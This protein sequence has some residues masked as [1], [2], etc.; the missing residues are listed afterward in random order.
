MAASD[1]D[2]PDQNGP[3]G[4]ED[5]ISQPAA[6]QWQ[7]PNGGNVCRINQAR[8]LFVKTQPS[9]SQR[10]GHVQREDRAHTVIAE[11][12]PHLGK[13][14]RGQSTW[15]TEKATVNRCGCRAQSC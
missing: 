13:E 2:A 3:A 4:S 15:M 7:V 12:L 6:D 1:H 9:F 8:I 10:L 11:P 14:K 5:L